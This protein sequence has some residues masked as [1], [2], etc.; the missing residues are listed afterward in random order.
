[1]IELRVLGIGSPFGDD[2]L[3]WEVIKLLRQQDPLQQYSNKRLQLL[4]CDRPGLHLLELMR[5]VK[6]IFLIDAVKINGEVGALHYLKNEEIE[7]ISPVQSTHELGVGYVMKIGNVL[8][9]LPQEI[10]FYGI[11][12]GDI[13]FQFELS[14]PIKNAIEKL[15][16][17]IGNDIASLLD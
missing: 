13:L 2:S 4:C 6:T 17:R 3:G 16:F 9:S 12:I 8:N 1:M 15:S 10:V 11:E 7:V 5:D 14:M